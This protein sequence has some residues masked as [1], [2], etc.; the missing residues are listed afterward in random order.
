MGIRG[1]TVEDICK[2][3]YVLKQVFL[4]EI[5][6]NTMKKKITPSITTGLIAVGVMFISDL[7]SFLSL[8]D[9]AWI[10]FVFWN[11]TAKE[12]IQKNKIQMLMK[13]ILGLP[14]GLMFAICMIHVPMLF[15]DN[16][17]VKYLIIFLC[18]GIA[19]LF[20]AGIMSGIFFGICLT[21]SGLGVGFFPDSIKNIL[22][23]LAVIVF[24][25]IIGMTA[26]WLTEKIQKIS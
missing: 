5:C 15:N 18:N 25:A 1:N 12:E 8:G 9:F 7:F 26:S 14:I 16:F 6:E 17:I 23:I 3:R 21:F 24:F 13:V 11:F 10:S 4:K 22:I 19:I 2:I 20:S